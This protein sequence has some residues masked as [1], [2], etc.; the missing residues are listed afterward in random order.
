[1]GGRS[2][3]SSS[4]NSSQ[5]SSTMANL[6]NQGVSNEKVAGM[7][8]DMANQQMSNVGGVVS[9]LIKDGME[10][11]GQNP[12]MNIMGGFL[13]MPIQLQTPSALEDFIAKYRPQEPQQPQQP[14]PYNVNDDMRARMGMGSPYGV[15]QYSVPNR[16]SMFGGR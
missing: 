10:M 15:G 7:Q 3:S 6:K 14:Q 2:K 9:S 12:M 8:Q 11:F 5:T 1:M 4:N 13:G 16:T